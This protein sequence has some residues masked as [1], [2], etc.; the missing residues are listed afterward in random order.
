MDNSGWEAAESKGKTKLDTSKNNKKPQKLCNSSSLKCIYTNVDSFLNKR[1]ELKTRIHIESPQIIGLTELKPK[2]ARFC[3]QPAE[4]KIDGYDCFHNISGEGRGVALYIKNDLH[5]AE[6]NFKDDVNTLDTIWAEIKLKGKDNLLIGC[7]YRSPNSLPE[8]NDQLTKLLKASVDQGY[9]H[10]VIMGDFNHPEITWSDGVGTPRCNEYHQASLFLETTRDLFLHQHIS[11]PTHFRSQQQPNT[12]DLLFSN[13]QYIINSV[14]MNSPIGK[15]H[16]VMIS[17]MIACDSDDLCGTKVVK[18]FHKVNTEEME[19]ELAKVDWTLSLNKSLEENWTFFEDTLNDCIKKYVPCKV[20][21][22][23][24]ASRN[25][26]W[27]NKNVRDLIR[28]KNSAFKKYLSTRT[29]SDYKNYCRLRNKTRKATR[30][31]AKQY[32]K[33]VVKFSKSNPKIFYKYTN[34]KLKT[35]SGIPTL[36]HEGKIYKSNTDKANLLNSHFSSVFTNEDLT[37]I[38]SIQSMSVRPLTSISITRKAIAD[39]LKNMKP[40]KSP[41]PDGISPVLLKTF[42]ETL[43]LPLEIIF[44]QSLDTGEI[45]SVWKKANITAIFKSNDKKDPNNYR[46]I[47]LTSVV[48]KV[49]ES[50]IRDQIME[51]LKLNNLLFPDQHGFVSGR[52][53]ITQLLS[54]IETWT[55]AIDHHLTTDTIYFDFQKAFDSVPHERLKIKLHQCGIRDPILNWISSFLSE[56]QQRVVVNDVLSQWEKVTS[57]VPQGSVLGPILFIIFINDIHEGINSCIKLYADD[58][59]LF[60]V[61]KDD[62]DPKTLQDDIY[63]LSSWAEKWQLKFHPEKCKIL[64][65]G[66]GN[67][68][69]YRLTNTDCDFLPRTQI[70]KDLGVYIDDKLNFNEHVSRAVT[71]ANQTL[72]LIRRSFQY[73]DKETLCLLFKSIVRPLLEYGNTIWHPILKRDI[74]K[75]ESVQRRATKLVPCLKNLPYAER[76][77]K[78]DLPSLSYRRNRG[79]MIETYKYVTKLYDTTNPWLVLDQDSVTRG[80]SHKLIT[81]RFNTNIRKNSF[82]N[83]IVNDWNSLPTHVIN[84]TTVNDFKNKLDSHWKDRKFIL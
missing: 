75:I 71:K 61:I 33:T 64:H 67:S 37:N 41:G 60:R 68:N 36:E 13:D 47:S 14:K 57:G 11:D 66:E 24:K 58:T 16:H 6:F 81:S 8:R 30:S 73:L 9:S 32:E 54:V 62:N 77:K 22:K 43:A 17:F 25:P 53:C 44:K 80:H 23:S 46:P 5:A 69:Y 26:A 4:L 70:Q 49:L 20:I 29:I 51:H 76:L 42:S 48:C 59:K 31:A 82:S 2:N 74:D 38:P 18:L 55:D 19:K 65:V 78:L 15:S 34:S 79:D 50:F 84:A 12:L 28:E 45:P 39:K 35:C 40:T 1:E 27:M 21:K 72:G 63:R 83:R 52:S 10:V 3:L 56:R 7:V